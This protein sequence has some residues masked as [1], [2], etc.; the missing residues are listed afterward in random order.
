MRW[1][2]M[3][4]NARLEPTTKPVYLLLFLD[5]C[6][7]VDA[8][9]SLDDL[10]NHVYRKIASYLIKNTNHRDWIGLPSS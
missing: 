7:L 10:L 3:Q 6:D 2:D 8:L 9:E 1:L 4:A 5:R